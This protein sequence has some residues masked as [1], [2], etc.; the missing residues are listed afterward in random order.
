MYKHRGISTFG[1]FI[2]VSLH[3]YIFSSLEV[4]PTDIDLEAVDD[5]TKL[6]ELEVVYAID[7]SV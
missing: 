3:L 1:A 6:G 7:P 5:S 4:V 2:C